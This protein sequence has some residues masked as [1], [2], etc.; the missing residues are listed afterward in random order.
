MANFTELTNKNANLKNA[1]KKINGIPVE[2]KGYVDVDTFGNVVNTIAKSCFFEGEYHAENREIARRFAILKYMTDIEVAEEDV[3]EIFKATQGGVWYN[4]I[5]REVI[6]LPLWAEIEQ[7]IDRQIDYYIT[8]R[9]TAFDKLCSDVSEI[10]K[11]D[12][13]QNLDD[14]KEV[15]DKLGKVDKQEFAEAITENA[16]KKTKAGGKNGNKKSKGTVDKTGSDTN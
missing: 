1:I 11:I 8:V 7:A 9:Q 15:L 14:L 4:E 5:E 3:N 10:L 6:K 16:V 12:M 2:I 13:T